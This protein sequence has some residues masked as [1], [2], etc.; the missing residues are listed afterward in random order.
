MDTKEKFFFTVSASAMT[1]TINCYVFPILDLLLNVYFSFFLG[2]Y[3][4]PPNVSNRPFQLDNQMECNSKQKL[5]LAYCS[6]PQIYS[7]VTHTTQ[8]KS[9]C[10]QYRKVLQMCWWLTGCCCIDSEVDFLM[11]SC[12][13]EGEQQFISFPT[14]I[15][16]YEFLSFFL[17]GWNHC[18][19][20]L[21]WIS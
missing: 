20:K 15:Y 1:G 14:T 7:S 19:F 2:G 12:A 5:L 13:E 10:V 11:E 3:T 8:T 18:S 6:R 4:L 16:V 17:L 21:N 9:K